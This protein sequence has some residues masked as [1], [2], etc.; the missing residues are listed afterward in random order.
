MAVVEQF[1]QGC[2]VTLKIRLQLLLLPDLFVL[3]RVAVVRVAEEVVVVRKKLYL[4]AF[5]SALQRV[6]S[7]SL[8]KCDCGLTLT[9]TLMS[10]SSFSVMSLPPTLALVSS[11][12]SSSVTG[13]LRS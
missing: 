11:L 4:Y 7:D 12:S 6:L 3:C 13:Q 5:N 2:D 8:M 10:K 9:A 1:Q